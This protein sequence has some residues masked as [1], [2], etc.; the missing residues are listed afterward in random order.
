[1][2][3]VITYYEIRESADIKFWHETEDVKSWFDQ[4]MKDLEGIGHICVDSMS[5]DKLIYT[6]QATCEDRSDYERKVLL[7]PVPN[8][9]D[10]RRKYNEENRI[11]AFASDEEL[12]P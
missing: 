4:Y 12:N 1:M 11:T 2:S 9:Q 8:F 10:L 7:C 3:Y 5:E 6:K